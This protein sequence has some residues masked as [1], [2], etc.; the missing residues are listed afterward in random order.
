MGR[1]T[2]TVLYYPCSVEKFP[3]CPNNKK[4]ISTALATALAIASNVDKK[5]IIVSIL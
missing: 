1:D 2:R 5:L 3:P 4:K